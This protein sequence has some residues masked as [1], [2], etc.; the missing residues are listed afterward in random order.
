M[1]GLTQDQLEEKLA[2]AYQII[3]TLL[4]DKF[5]TAEGQRVLDYFSRDEFDESFLPWPRS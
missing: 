4:G 1:T 2:Q 5:E 3:G